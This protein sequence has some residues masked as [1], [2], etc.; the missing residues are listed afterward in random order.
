VP[1]CDADWHYG[2]AAFVGL[3]GRGTV[4]GFVALPGFGHVHGCGHGRCVDLPYR[5]LAG[6]VGAAGLARIQKVVL[7]SLSCQE[8]K[9]LVAGLHRCG[10]CVEFRKALLTNSNG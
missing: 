3:G 5:K 9:L 4:L 1:S 6:G 8:E 10:Q 2:D 7:G